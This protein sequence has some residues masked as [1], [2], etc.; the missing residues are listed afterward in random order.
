[1]DELFFYSRIRQPQNYFVPRNGIEPFYSRIWAVYGH[2]TPRHF[3]GH[4]FII[5]SWVSTEPVEV[6]VGIE[7]TWLVLQTNS[8]TARTYHHF[9]YPWENRTPPAWTKTMCTNRYTKGQNWGRHG[10]RT[11]NGVTR[12]L[13]SRQAP[14]PFGRLPFC[15]PIFQITYPLFWR[16]KGNP[17]FLTS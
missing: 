4:R 16:D 3:G 1:M 5:Y 13:F 2:L 11:H 6:I 8:L 7:P 15:L 10:N 12:Y 17:F 9:C 14:R